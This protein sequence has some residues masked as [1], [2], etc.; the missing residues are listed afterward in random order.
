MTEQIKLYGVTGRPILHSLSPKI[1]N[2]V[3][4]EENEK[5]V[6]LRLAAHTAADAIEMATEM[7]IRGLNVTAPFKETMIA[8]LKKID[9]VAAQFQAV[10]TIAFDENGFATGYNTDIDGVFSMLQQVDGDIGAK[11][12]VVLGAGGAARSALFA[13]KARSVSDIVIINRSIE[14]GSELA[15]HFSCRFVELRNARSTIQSADIVLSCLP[16]FVTLEEDLFQKKQIILDASYIESG[17]SHSARQ[18]GCIYIGGTQWLLA[19]AMSGYKILTGKEAPID[20]IAHSLDFLKESHSIKSFN[21]LMLVGMMGCG[22]TTVGK[23][24]AFLLKRQFIDSDRWI[25]EREGCSIDQIFSQQG[26]AAFREIEA[27]CIEEIMD[28]KEHCVVALGGG[29][30]EEAGTRESVGKNNMVV[31]LQTPLNI[32]AERCK[33]DDRPLLKGQK[34]LAIMTDLMTKRLRHYASCSDLVVSTT[35]K[36]PQEIGLMVFDEISKTELC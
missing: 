16:S 21:H 32:C 11:R 18:A 8:Q 14:R 2:T 23:E 34:A 24:I 25:E 3:F 36:S 1:F 22:K 10:N 7:G 28:Q 4:S 13:L 33:F 6:Y 5:A 15:H 17:C 29:A 19:Q 31:W 30:L 35:K 9:D 26:E 27:E 20:K 12:V